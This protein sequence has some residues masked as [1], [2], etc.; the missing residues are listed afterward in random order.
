M[1][2]FNPREVRGTPETMSHTT[3]EKRKKIPA[4]LSIIATVTI[5]NSSFLWETL[6]LGIGLSIELI[7]IRKFVYLILCS[8][9]INI[10][11]NCL[12]EYFQQN[13]YILPLFSFS[14]VF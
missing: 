14:D 1:D 7:A 2:S 4:V 8:I 10:V 9:S 3:I 6:F 13:F 12:L 11:V 5:C